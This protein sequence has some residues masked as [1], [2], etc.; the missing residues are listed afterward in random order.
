MFCNFVLISLDITV[1]S[2]NQK[3]FEILFDPSPKHSGRKT[4]CSVVSCTAPRI[5]TQNGL[6]FAGDNGLLESANKSEDRSGMMFQ[7]CIPYKHEDT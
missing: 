4:C 2:F 3:L 1:E 6:P 5:R 7:I